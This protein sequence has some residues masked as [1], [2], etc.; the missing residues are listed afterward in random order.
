VLQKA[1]EKL[2]NRFQ[3]DFLDDFVAPAGRQKRH[4]LW[5]GRPER[6]SHLHRISARTEIIRAPQI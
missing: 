3:L 1:L 5:F 2:K 4:F 6:Q